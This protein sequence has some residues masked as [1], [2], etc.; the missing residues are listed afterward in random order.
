M[1]RELYD[2]Q[3]ESKLFDYQLLY[4]KMVKAS[5]LLSAETRDEMIE[6][7]TTIGNAISEIAMKVEEREGGRGERFEK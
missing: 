2:S 5:H 1:L 6:A 7:L 4:R 3:L